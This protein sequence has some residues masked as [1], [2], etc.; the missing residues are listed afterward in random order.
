M[1][2]QG[3]AKYKESRFDEAAQCYTNAIELVACGSS[4]LALTCYSRPPTV[5]LP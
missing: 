4:D 3:N 5:H 1:N 2:C